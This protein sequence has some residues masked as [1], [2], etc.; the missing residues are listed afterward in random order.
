LFKPSV[1]WNYDNFLFTTRRK[2]E[3]RQKEGVFFTRLKVKLRQFVYNYHIE[4][5][6]TKQIDKIET[7]MFIIYM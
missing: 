2:I 5:F 1:K 7:I 6:I 4:H 3:L